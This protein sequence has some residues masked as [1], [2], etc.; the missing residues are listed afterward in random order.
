MA[1]DVNEVIERAIYGTP[2]TKPGERR[3]FL[4]TILERIHVALTLKQVQTSAPYEKV[5]H[6]MK[7]ESNLH[8]YLNGNLGYQA[9]ADYMQAANQNG[10][11]FTVVTPH[12]ETPFGLV[13]ANTS[14]PVHVSDPFIKDALHEQDIKNF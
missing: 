9:Y 3:L 2:E 7:T 10:I 4:T 13:L 12:Q 11:P 1:R 8:L 5:T 14:T 6:V